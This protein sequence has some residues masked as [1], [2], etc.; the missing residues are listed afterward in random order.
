MKNACE[1]AIRRGRWEDLPAV[2]QLICDMERT[3][4]P[5]DRFSAIYLDRLERPEEVFLVYQ[6]GDA[7]VGVLHLRMEP[8]LHHAAL[9]AEVMELAVAAGCRNRGLGRA[10]LKEARRLAGEAGCIQLEVACNRLRTDAHRFYRREGLEDFHLK[11][12]VDLT[13][14]VPAG[15]AIGR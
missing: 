11:F 9:V 12:S 5:L 1:A 3:R 4:L 7:V 8:Q 13:G 14:A 10:L 6:E 15:N 2:Y